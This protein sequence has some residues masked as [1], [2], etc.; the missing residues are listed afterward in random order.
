MRKITHLAAAIMVAACLI[1]Q[2]GAVHAA[3]ED[4]DMSIHITKEVYAEE[5]YAPSGEN[6]VYL[7]GDK[8]A[9]DITVWATLDEDLGD[10]VEYILLPKVSDEWPEEI[11]Y[12]G[13]EV[14]HKAVG[15]DGMGGEYTVTAEVTDFLQVEMYDE[16]WDEQCMYTGSDLKFRFTGEVK[17][18]LEEGEE[19]RTVTNTAQFEAMDFEPVTDEAEITVG[20]NEEP[21]AADEPEDTQ[22]T[23]DPAGPEDPEETKTPDTPK[24]PEKPAVA[25]S[26]DAPRTGDAAGGLAAALAMLILSGGGAGFALYRKLTG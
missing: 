11:E 15:D 14:L 5:E 18:C 19:L 21:E 6:G 1:P 24:D 22:I 20:R 7:P 17:D 3:M 13:F 10:Y 26:D 2:V 25:P 23:E 16:D 9:F 4:P 12:T 8:V